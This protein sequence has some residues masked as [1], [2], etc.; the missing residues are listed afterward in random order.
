MTFRRNLR[1]GS[2]IWLV[3]LSWMLGC[4]LAS[5][6]LVNYW[7]HVLDGYS[8]T[9]DPLGLRTNIARDFGLTNNNVAVG[10]DNIGEVVSWTAKE[11]GGALRLNEQFGFGFDSAHNLRS[12]TNGAL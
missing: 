11:S 3:F 6:A 12:R 9:H 8:Y 10:Y 5:P 7:G 4:G 2:R 1:S